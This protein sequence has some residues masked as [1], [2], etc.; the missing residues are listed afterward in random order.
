MSA[1][2]FSISTSGSF[3]IDPTSDSVKKFKTLKYPDTSKNS[4][5]TNSL[6]EESISKGSSIGRTFQL[7]PNV[8]FIIRNI[9]FNKL[10]TQ[11][12]Y[13]KGE[14]FFH[15]FIYSKARSPGF[16]QDDIQFG[17]KQ[18]TSK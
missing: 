3:K 1:L 8:K 4:L 14:N 10:F 6:S 7:L 5:S 16:F 15:N 13:F 2:I 17:C 12:I 11:N 18:T 9:I